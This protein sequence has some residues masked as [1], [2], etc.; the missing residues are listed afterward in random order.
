MKLYYDKI[1]KRGGRLDLGK[2]TLLQG[3]MGTGK[4]AIVSAVHLALSGKIPALRLGKGDTQDAGRLLKHVGSG[5]FAMIGLDGWHGYQVEATEKKARVIP[6]SS[7]DGVAVV[8]CDAPDGGADLVFADLKRLTSCSD[9][10]RAELLATY[11]P[12]PEERDL[13]GWALA[14]AILHMGAS[15]RPKKKNDAGPHLVSSKPTRDEAEKW[16][17]ALVKLAD[18]N[19]ATPVLEAVL[20]VW[21]NQDLPGVEELIEALRQGS[22]AAAEQ[23]RTASAA[24]KQGLRS[25]PGDP[26]LIEEIPA[27]ESEVST[28]RASRDHAAENSRQVD[29]ARKSR[30]RAI[31]ELRT[32]KASVGALNSTYT[33][34]T[35]EAVKAAGKKAAA[36]AD[37][38]RQSEPKPPNDDELAKLR[39]SIL[40]ITR[41]VVKVEAE[42]RGINAEGKALADV[43]RKVTGEAGVVCPLIGTA[44]NADL[45]GWLAETKAKLAELVKVR[46]PAEERLAAGKEELARVNQETD[47]LL[48][49]RDNYIAAQRDWRKALDAA[50]EAVRKAARNQEQMEREL[51]S[52]PTIEARI[53]ELEAAL[54][55]MPEAIESVAWTA[56]QAERLTEAEGKLKTAHAAQA[57]KDV[58]ASADQDALETAAKLWKSAHAGASAGVLACRQATVAPILQ[59]ASEALS[60]FGIP[61]MVVIDLVSETIGLMNADNEFI[62]IE[63]LSAGQQVFYACAL[64]SVVPQKVGPRVLTIEVAE[65]RTEWMTRLMA[66]FDLTEWDCILLATCHDVAEVPEGWNVHRCE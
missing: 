61:G 8:P 9:K 55:E 38:I 66:G 46:A 37:K 20:A 56:D 40:G 60:R 27:L 12:R 34:A 43:A 62:D 42:I 64:L 23:K 22:N 36:D 16:R 45:S 58:L 50:D 54:E 10:E 47:L 21:K 2:A 65:V 63:A 59:G 7:P 13:R 19:R 11:L 31:E 30:D 39:Q 57:R 18:A 17:D 15:L 33:T 53:A 3:D 25:D 41:G 5:G 48:R 24:L 28:L 29:A 6:V 44:C 32:R 49:A 51:A 1:K 4:S 52:L 14:Q 26:A 35:I